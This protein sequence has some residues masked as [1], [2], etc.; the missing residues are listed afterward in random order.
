MNWHFINTG[1]QSGDWNMAFD[2]YA[3]THFSPATDI[4]LLRIFA[5][6]PPTI[7][8]GANQREDDFNIAKI[9]AD[10]LGLV[11]RPTGGRAIFHAHELTYSIVLGAKGIGARDVYHELSTGILAALRYL[12]IAA[13]IAGSDERTSPFS[14]PLSLPC[15]GTSTRSEIQ[16]AG[17]KIVGS[18]Q[19]RYDDTILQHGSFLLGTRHRDLVAYLTPEA[20]QARTALERLLT[21]RTTEAETVLGR[22]VSYEEAVTAFKKGFESAY[23]LTF[24]EEYP[25]FLRELS[26]H[27][28]HLQPT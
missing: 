7:S 11:R 18:A 22:P 6:N 1:Y 17:K 14:D 4:P 5:W 2:E 13:T 28:Q 19:R 20:E 27:S 12:G 25:G 24:I 16:V 9:H 26:T 15:F 10:G 21:S 3:A 23:G 8:I